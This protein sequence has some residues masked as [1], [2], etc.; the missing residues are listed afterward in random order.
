LKG[1]CVIVLNYQLWFK[2]VPIGL[3]RYKEQKK[4]ETEQKIKDAFESLKRN[5]KDVNINSIAKMAG[6]SAVTV[7]KYSELAELKEVQACLRLLR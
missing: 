2:G 7:Y 6:I 4:I 3:N 1:K 5:K